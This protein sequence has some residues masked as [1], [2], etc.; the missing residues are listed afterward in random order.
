MGV[1]RTTGREKMIVLFAPFVFKKARFSFV[2]PPFTLF[3]FVDSPFLISFSGGTKK[4][5]LLHRDIYTRAYVTGKKGKPFLPSRKTEQTKKGLRTSQKQNKRPDK[6]G[7]LSCSI[8]APPLLVSGL[9]FAHG[10]RLLTPYMCSL[11]PFLSLF[12][13]FFLS[14]FSLFEY[15]K[16]FYT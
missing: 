12:V 9:L 3:F 15:D 2:L 7:S 11:L 10:R 1:S 4:K 16:T 13:A 14:R 5:H 6:S 8:R